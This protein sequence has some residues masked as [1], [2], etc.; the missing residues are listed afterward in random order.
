MAIGWF[1]TAARVFQRR[2]ALPQPFELTCDCGARIAGLRS[3][4]PQKPSCPS[5]GTPNFVLPACQYPIPLSV[6][7]D[8]LGEEAAPVASPPKTKVP[9]KSSPAVPARKSRRA[10]AAEAA[11][12]A[13]PPTAPRRALSE[14][15]RSAATPVRM[16]VL[17]I[18]AT[19]V[20]T[21]AMLVRGARL[22][23]AREHLRPAIDRGLAALAEQDLSAA[24]DAFAEACLALDRLGRN[25]AAALAVRRLQQETEIA[26]RLSGTPLTEVLADV[27]VARQ[28]A[29]LVERF[30]SR[31]A[32]EWYLFDAVVQPERGGYQGR[33]P[34]CVVDVPLGLGKRSLEV[35]FDEVPWPMLW[36]SWG[37]EQPQRLVFAAELDRIEFTR[38]GMGTRNRATLLLRTSTAVLWCHG[39]TLEAVLPGALD[40]ELAA[41]LRDAL[42]RQRA[43][44]GVGDEP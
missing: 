27:S 2:E 39:Q 18:L 19:I 5:C 10:L 23:W 30:Q 22:E 36:K 29:D 12:T 42:Q 28:N 1:H 6:R 11:E 38:D 4:A 40:G 37:Y 16:V 41:E 8:W 33:V 7:R 24:N 15:L 32:G 43:A 44:L 31:G 26:R 34:R 20:L 21:A 13:P 14:R 25:D 9:P 35:A 3:E 17:M